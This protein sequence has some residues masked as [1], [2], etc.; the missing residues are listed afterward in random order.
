MGSIIFRMLFFAI[1]IILLLLSSVAI[2]TQHL[3]LF[4]KIANLAFFVLAAGTG[5]YLYRLKR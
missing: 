2:A 4:L 1:G 3:G 5:W